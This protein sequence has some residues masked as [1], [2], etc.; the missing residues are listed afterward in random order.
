[1]DK[2]PT[3]SHIVDENCDGCAYCIEPCPANAITLIEYMKQGQIKKTVQV[4]DALCRGCG[5]CMATCPKQGAFVH[6][7]K[8]EYLSAMVNAVLEGVVA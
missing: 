2:S 6:H 5:M 1:M 3:I 8:P 7:F 4:N